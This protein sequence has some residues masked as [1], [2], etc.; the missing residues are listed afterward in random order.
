MQ[1]YFYSS[2][3]M[4]F[5]ALLFLIGCRSGPALPDAGIESGPSTM[6]SGDAG[7]SHQCL[8]YYMLAVDSRTYE[9]D[10]LP[11]RTG[12]WH[13]NLTGILNTTMGVSAAGVPSEHDPANG[14][15]VFDI[16]LAHPFDTS[17]QLAGFDVKGILVTPGTYAVGSLVYAGADET[18]LENADGYSR[19]WNPTEFTSPGMLGYENGIL[20]SAPGSLLTAT[21]NPYKYF[22]DILYPTSSLGSVCYEPLDSDQGRGVFTA[23]SSNTRRYEI[24]FPMDPGPQIV[25]GYAIDC[26]W[27]P[28]SPNPPGEVPD[29]FPMNANQPEAYR[30]GL[31]TTAN[32]LYYD[33][34]SGI[35]GGVLRLEIGVFDW[36]GQAAGNIVPEIDAV[37]IVAPDLMPSGID[38]VLHEQTPEKAVYT[39]DL[40]GTAIP[41]EAGGTLVIC[42]VASSDG[43][44]YQQAGAPAPDT[45]ISAFHVITLD[46]FDPDCAADDNNDYSQAVELNIGDFVADEVCI[47]DDMK[48]FYFFNIDP[49]Y[50]AVGT[51][52][53]YSDAGPASMKL[54]DESEDIITGASTSGN[55][56]ELSFDKLDLMP[57]LYYL[58]VYPDV[59][60]GVRPYFLE[61]DAE[62]IDVTPLNPL[63]VTPS[64]LYVNPNKVWIHNNMA[65]LVGKGTWVYDVSDPGN[66]V[67]LSHDLD[68]RMNTKACFK[69]PYCYMV[70]YAGN[71]EDRI[72]LIDFSDPYA[73]VLHEDV[74]HYPTQ[75]SGICINSTHLYVTTKVNPTSEAI[76]YDYASDPLNPAVVDSFNV[77]YEAR[78]LDLL[79]PEGSGTHLVIGTWDDILTYDVEVPSSVTQT[80]TYTFPLGPPRDIATWDDYIYVAHDV[81][82]GG[83]GWLYVLRQTLV[84]DIVEESTLDTPGFASNITIAWPYV[85]M[86]D[87]DAGLT[88]VNVADPALPV[89]ESS[90][91][92]VSVGTHLAEDNDVVYIIPMG[93]GLQA[94]D[95]SDPAAPNTLS[96]LQVVNRPGSMVVKD[97]YLI[98]TES[99]MY[100]KGFKTVDISD[101]PNASVVAEHFL[102]EQP[103]YL[104]LDGNNLIARF[105]M[106]WGLYDATDPLNITHHIS[107]PVSNHIWS[108]AVRGDA[109]YVALEPVGG[110]E[111]QIF[112]ISVPAAPTYE[113]AI[114]LTNN[115]CDISFK[116]NYMYLNNNLEILVYS[117]TDPFN[118]VFEGN[119]LITYVHGMD[120]RGDYLH[121][122]TETDVEI[123]DISIPGSPVFAGSTTLPVTY[124]NSIIVG[125]QFVYAVTMNDGIY[126]CRVWPPDSPSPFG[127]VTTD[128]YGGT[129][130]LTHEGFLYNASEFAGI[131]IFDLY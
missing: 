45:Q 29:D 39:V 56:A 74:L 22:A 59:S 40:T 88:T 65:F 89:H 33:S 38:G 9:I 124:I 81:S 95:V 68:I 19:W 80:G 35:G 84:P 116:E 99:G 53:L 83:E 24:R 120:I 117:L 25:Y 43:S 104:V 90:I 17:P 91:P 62:L 87:G 4:I 41:S 64:D 96:R 23:G 106:L 49:D 105:N 115:V 97:G 112:D 108:M 82:G 1:R 121:M 15:F 26:A 77:P 70:K 28:P 92:L 50:E 85:Y 122:A 109:F 14:L 30:I 102:T 5:I 47:P 130:L 127:P 71:W 2:A 21:V 114:S 118:P 42:R 58:Q 34:E 111:I 101:P 10:V 78:L 18:R 20:A 60:P 11:L 69:Y 66:P 79:D 110:P 61:L 32:T 125:G 52:Y 126:T 100:H 123:V 55:I 107:V 103:T 7:Q 86:G 8:G 57:G 3:F 44:T 6:F 72:D 73:P 63:D 12:E 119:Y 75:I 46:I 51:I 16:T 36:Q 98:V 76:I 94:V 54:Y 13:F 131:R 93:A 48:D 37:R 128:D 129:F 27:N 31:K 113:N 67:Q